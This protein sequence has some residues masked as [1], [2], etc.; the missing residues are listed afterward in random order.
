MC[1]IIALLVDNPHLGRFDSNLLT[2]Q[3]L[4]EMLVEGFHDEI[5]EEYQ[6]EN[7]MFLD[8]CQW[9]GVGCD[10]AQN[11]TSVSGFRCHGLIALD[12]IP[13]KVALFKMVLGSLCG[14]LSTNTIPKGMTELNLVNNCLSGTVDFMMLPECMQQLSLQ[15]NEFTGSAN[16]HL[17]PNALEKLNIENNKF[18]GSLYLKSLPLNFCYLDVSSNMLSGVFSIENVPKGLFTMHA[19]YNRFDEVAVVPSHVNIV[20]LRN[21]GVTTVVDEFERKHPKEDGILAPDN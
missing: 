5:K 8:V 7:G 3:S 14:T 12:F 17:L 18:S 6:D 10:D 4:M 15:Y 1:T 13:P 9:R 16:F 21:C 2:D 19:S 20:T 11:V